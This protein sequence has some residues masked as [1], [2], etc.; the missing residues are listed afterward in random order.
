M[1]RIGANMS[2]QKSR[3]MIV[4]GQ[5]LKQRGRRG[6]RETTAHEYGDSFGS[7]KIVIK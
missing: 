5:G 1:S 6:A 7:D 4:Y 2:G 3:Y